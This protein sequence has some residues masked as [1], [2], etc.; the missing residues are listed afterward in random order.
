MSLIGLDLNGS[1][2]RA[3]GGPGEVQPRALNLDGKNADLPMALSLEN[4]R[5]EVGP[6]GLA[7]CRRLPHLT[8]TNFLAELGERRQWGSGRK[9]IDSGKALTLVFDHIRSAC[10]GAK[11]LVASLP[12]YLNRVQ[13]DLASKLA[14]KAKLPWLGSMSAP[15]AVALAS[16]ERE[17]VESPAPHVS[18]SPLRTVILD[19]D[20]HAFS[21]SVVEIGPERVFVVA[22]QSVPQLSLLVWKRR[23]LDSLSERCI[24]H[25]R[26][27]PRESGQAEQALYDQ[28]DHILDC[29]WQGQTAEAVVRASSWFQDL[30]LRPEEISQ[31]CGPLVRHALNELGQATELNPD[32]KLTR[33]LMTEAAGRL[34]GLTPALEDWGRVE[35]EV[36]VLPPNAVARAAHD[37]SARIV[38]GDLPRGHLDTTVPRNGPTPQTETRTTKK[39]KISIFGE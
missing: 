3:V 21:W 18:G 36:S 29:A 32:G 39:R 5:P 20:D 33:I 19:V 35:T 14:E 25:S 17:R 1:R 9:Q 4:R 31:F 11:G 23:L 6:A 27:D 12:T 2:V 26:R 30:L 15:L 7:L 38:R 37:L 28:L 22:E 16:Q 10:R 24:R 34:P 8:C 13:A